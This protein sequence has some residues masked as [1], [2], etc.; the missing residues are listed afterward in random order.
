[1]L[2]AHRY[3][4]SVAEHASRRLVNFLENSQGLVQTRNV[5]GVA[6]GSLQNYERAHLDALAATF[7]PKLPLLPP[8]LV[9][10]VVEYAFHVGDY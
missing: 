7:I 10:R 2:D 5:I 6:A 3:R 9:R 8:E 1:M 4:V